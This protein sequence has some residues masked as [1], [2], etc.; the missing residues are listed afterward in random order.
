MEKQQNS[1]VTLLGE[2]TNNT[3]ETETKVQIKNLPYLESN[4]TVKSHIWKG[5]GQICINNSCKKRVNTWKGN[6]I[7][8]CKVSDNQQTQPR[9]DRQ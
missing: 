1:S 4:K 8:K 2:G 9:C 3:E 6:N 7:R 5:K